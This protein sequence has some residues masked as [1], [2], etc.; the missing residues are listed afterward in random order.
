MFDVCFVSGK[1]VVKTQDLFTPIQEPFAQVG[2]NKPG[3]PGYQIHVVDSVASSLGAAYN[4]TAT[5]CGRC[6]DA[7]PHGN[8][9]RGY[10]SIHGELGKLK[11][12]KGVARVRQRDLRWIP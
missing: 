7:T 9:D 4:T 12:T 2:S 5:R 3:S 1:E 10:D 6:A 8:H 11:R